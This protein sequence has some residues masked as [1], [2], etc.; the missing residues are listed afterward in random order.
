MVILPINF[1]KFVWCQHQYDMTALCMHWF[2]CT[3]K[4]AACSLILSGPEPSILQFDT[5]YDDVDRGE[6]CTE[7]IQDL[8]FSHEGCVNLEMFCATDEEPA[9]HINLSSEDHQIDG[10]QIKVTELAQS[11]NKTHPVIRETHDLSNLETSMEKLRVEKFAHE[12]CMDL[13]MFCGAKEEP[14]ELVRKFNE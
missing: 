5:C 14:R 12:E 6:A 7:K 2:S 8:T 1:G 9:D 11:E 10:E 4:H 13:D 3:E